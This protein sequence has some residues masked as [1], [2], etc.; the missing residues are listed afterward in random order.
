MHHNQITIYGATELHKILSLNSL[1]ITFFVIL[2]TL[3]IAIDHANY[4]LISKVHYPDPKYF[5][6]SKS[7]IFACHPFK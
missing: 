3:P 7:K 1:K 2:K 4:M 6:Q 5:K